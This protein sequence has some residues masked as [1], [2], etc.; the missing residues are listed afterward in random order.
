[1]LSLGVFG[2]VLQLALLGQDGGDLKHL[3][4]TLGIGC[5]NERRVNEQASIRLE[6]E[7]GC[8]SEIVSDARHC[9]N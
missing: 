8:M 6:K 5:R 3:T 9:S 2:D 4:S 7:V 1:M